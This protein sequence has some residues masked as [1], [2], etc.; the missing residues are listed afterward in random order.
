MSAQTNRSKTSEK[1]S[2]DPYKWLSKSALAMADIYEKQFQTGYDMFNN[3]INKG[4]GNVKNNSGFNTE[5]FHSSTEMMRNNI[6]NFSKLSEKTIS[7]LMSSYLKDKSKSNEES[8]TIETIIDAYNLQFKQMAD[9]NQHFFETFSK[10]FKTAKIDIEDYYT[11]FR[12]KTEENFRVAEEAI[13]DTLKNYSSTV[14]KSEKNR[15]EMLDN[16]N[17]QIEF[18]TKSSLKQWMDFIETIKKEKKTPAEKKQ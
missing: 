9:M 14:N 8:K 4:D 18:V 15:E 5:A 3:F 11:D 1:N 16:I 13:N 2:N 10:T 7:S 17:K 12:K 6:E